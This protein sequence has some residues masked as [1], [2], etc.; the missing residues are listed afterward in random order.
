VRESAA[1]TAVGE[2]EMKICTAKSPGQNYFQHSIKR[3]ENGGQSASL[4][5][6]FLDSHLARF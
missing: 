4:F 5:A 6:S 1:V 3:G 2:A